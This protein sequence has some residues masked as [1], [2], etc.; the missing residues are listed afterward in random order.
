MVFKRR[1][2]I[3]G[4]LIISIKGKEE[5]FSFRI[6]GIFAHKNRILLQKATKSGAWVLPGGRSEVI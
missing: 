1:N 4:I 3:G 5:S 6:A 2:I